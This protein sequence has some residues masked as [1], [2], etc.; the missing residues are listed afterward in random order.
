MRTSQKTEVTRRIHSGSPHL[1]DLRK[2]QNLVTFS[3]HATCVH[4][5]R[6]RARHGFARGRHHRAPVRASAVSLVPPPHG[7]FNQKNK[8]GFTN[9]LCSEKGKPTRTGS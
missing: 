8:H 1:A 2:V 5:L 3:M 4:R 6:A 7:G 9:V